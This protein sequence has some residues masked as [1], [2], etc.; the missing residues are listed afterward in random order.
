M[1]KERCR[2]SLERGISRGRSIRAASGCLKS[3]TMLMETLTESFSSLLLK[4]KSKLC[5]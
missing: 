1:P 2:R 3:V 4:V 5:N